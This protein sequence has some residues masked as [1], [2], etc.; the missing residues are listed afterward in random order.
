MVVSYPPSI[1]KAGYF[2]GK[3]SYHGIG[4]HPFVVLLLY[5][6]SI[7]L[8]SFSSPTKQPKSRVLITTHLSHELNLAGYFP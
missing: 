8:G 6:G 5:L 7:E 2:P 4:I 3:D 1:N